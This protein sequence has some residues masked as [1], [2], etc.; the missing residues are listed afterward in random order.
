MT[1][2]VVTVTNGMRRASGAV[3]IPPIGYIWLTNTVDVSFV[4][5]RNHFVLSIFH[6]KFVGKALPLLIDLNCIT[7]KVRE[8]EGG[9]T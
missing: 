6:R 7:M 3:V 9:S 1:C 8:K 4:V 5:N 2:M